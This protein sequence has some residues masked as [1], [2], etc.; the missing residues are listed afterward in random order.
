MRVS[1]F[2]W[3]CSDIE[4]QLRLGFVSFATRSDRE[5]LAKQTEDELLNVPEGGRQSH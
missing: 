4:P 2:Y 3:P 1:I 5:V